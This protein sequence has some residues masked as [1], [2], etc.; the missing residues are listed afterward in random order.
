MTIALPSL[1][2]ALLTA[3]L[4]AGLAFL[5]WLWLRRELTPKRF[6]SIW[7]SDGVLSTRLLL[8]TVLSGFG[9]AMYA[10]GRMDDGGLSQLLGWVTGMLAVGGVVKAAAS[11]KS[12]TTNVTT[13]TLN[14]EVSADTVNL[15]GKPATPNPESE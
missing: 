5:L 14:A 11:L 6:L 15:N 8:A 12:E 4:W 3:L 2:F 1:S 10:A 9:M 13:K 7:E